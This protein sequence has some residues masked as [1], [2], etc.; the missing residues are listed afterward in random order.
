MTL[1]KDT[2]AGRLIY[3][4]N[5]LEQMGLPLGRYASSS[6]PLFFTLPTALFTVRSVSASSFAGF[7]NDAAASGSPFIHRSQASGSRTFR[8]GF[9]PASVV[10]MR[11]LQ[12]SVRIL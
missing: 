5:V 1:R 3:Q 11:H 8:F 6:G 7:I 9:D 4:A 10:A 12:P 2:I